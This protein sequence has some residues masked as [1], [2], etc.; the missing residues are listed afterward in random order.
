MQTSP[1]TEK[2]GTKFHPCVTP[3]SSLFTLHQAA[4]SSSSKSLSCG[5]QRRLF[6]S[7]LPGLSSPSRG[8]I[9][10]VPLLHCG[11]KSVVKPVVL[12][13]HFLPGFLIQNGFRLCHLL[14]QLRKWGG[15]CRALRLPYHRPHLLKTLGRRFLLRFQS[16]LSVHALALCRLSFL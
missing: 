8:A 2:K 7:S 13:F 6:F 16:A 9:H 3:F 10:P 14:L 5:F 1:V 12:L 11:G 15:F 4:R